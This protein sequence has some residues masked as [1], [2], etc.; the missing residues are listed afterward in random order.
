MLQN[1]GSADPAACRKADELREQLRGTLPY[2][3]AR[4]VRVLAGTDVAGTVADEIALLAGH[5]LTA[6]QAVAAAGARAREFLG[7]H[8][9]GDIVTTT[10]TRCRTRGCW[11]G[12]RPSWSAGSGSGARRPGKPT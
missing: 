4:S 11:P 6:A 9:D 8:P 10:P 12:P 1:R 5:G 2:A 3:V 7:I